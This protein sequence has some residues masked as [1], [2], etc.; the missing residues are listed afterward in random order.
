MGN[1]LPRESK[2]KDR[3]IH[4]IGT[5]RSYTEKELQRDLA[6][7]Y[8]NISPVVLE[9]MIR[10]VIKDLLDSK[11]IKIK[12]DSISLTRDGI[13]QFKNISAQKQA[14][15]DR[16]LQK[17]ANLNKRLQKDIFEPKMKEMQEK[18]KMSKDIHD[19][20]KL[21]LGELALLLGIAWKQEH[22]LVKR[23]PVRL[24]MVW[25]ADPRTIS[26]A[27]EIQHRGNLKEAIGNLEAVNRYYPD[28]RL[29]VIIFNE[30]QISHANQLLG[31]RKDSI[32]ILKAS[33]I[34]EW[35]SVLEKVHGELSPQII[36]V[37]KDIVD[38]GLSPRLLI[39]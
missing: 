21:Q 28:C 3:I 34:R 26:H 22:E 36:N 29:F 8:L 10:R 9:S 20:L 12:N 1:N 15:L 6:K 31:T 27:F 4:A 14:K 5:R 18:R 23:G 2:L 32:T 7:I 13:N 25:Y 37:V 30:K 35:L 17:K 16:R 24:D 33:Q 39:K 11:L 38:H 19:K